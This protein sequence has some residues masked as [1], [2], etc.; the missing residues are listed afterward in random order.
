VEGEHTRHVEI[1]R[2]LLAEGF[3]PQASAP[4]LV[5]LNRYELTEEELAQVNKYRQQ[6][7]SGS[8]QDNALDLEAQERTARALYGELFGYAPEREQVTQQLVPRWYNLPTYIHALDM[9]ELPIVGYFGEA[10]IFGMDVRETLETRE[11]M[12]LLDRIK[13]ATGDYPTPE[14]M[15]LVATHETICTD[16]VV[17]AA[18]VDYDKLHARDKMQTVDKHD[19]GIKEAKKR[20][21]SAVSARQAQSA[22]EEGSMVLWNAW[23][24]G[25]HFVVEHTQEVAQ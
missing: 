8:D 9:L 20:K 15:G 1:R 11:M 2:Q 21:L 18:T 10:P 17:R 14:E 19:R 3:V 12:Q 16:R 5:C 24:S 4:Y 13:E 6:Q 23:N 25:K 22:V 7:A